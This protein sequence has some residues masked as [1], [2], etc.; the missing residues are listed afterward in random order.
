MPKIQEDLIAREIVI[1]DAESY[2]RYRITKRQTQDEIQI[3]TGAIVITRQVAHFDVNLRFYL[4]IYLFCVMLI[5]NGFCRGKYRPPNA[6]S[7]G[8]KPLYLHISAG[9]H[10][11][12][13]GKKIEEQL[14]EAK[15]ASNRDLMRFGIP[16]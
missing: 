4:F 16:G 2:V 1:N 12:E 8:E 10:L 15:S 7:D 6:P 11:G 3:S 14:G 13:I 5:S 9:T